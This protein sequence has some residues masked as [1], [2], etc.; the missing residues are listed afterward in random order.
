MG[1]FER[2]FLGGVIWLTEFV[3]ERFDQ[4]KPLAR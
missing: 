2:H 3:G 1:L 4:V